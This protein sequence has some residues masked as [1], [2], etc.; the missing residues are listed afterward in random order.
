MAGETDDRSF[1]PG[2]DWADK[3][4][5]APGVPDDPDAVPELLYQVL[6][7]RVFTLTR[8]RDGST[9]RGEVPLA[10]LERDHPTSGLP[11]ALEVGREVWF[12]PASM[13]GT[14]ATTPFGVSRPFAPS[15]SR[16]TPR[17]SRSTQ[18]W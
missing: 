10:D 1:E 13:P 16:S 5:F 14:V 12:A 15:H 6:L 7:G 17:A 3:T 4:S 18:G 11:P 2:P 9:A 8:W